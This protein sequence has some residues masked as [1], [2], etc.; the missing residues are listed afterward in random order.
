MQNTD[1]VTYYVA[2]DDT[3]MRVEA[4]I[5]GF[6]GAATIDLSGQ[7]QAIVDLPAES[8]AISIDKVSE[9]YT[10]LRPNF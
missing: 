8:D 3:L 6:K 9:L 10:K 4:D 2:E 7:T 1:A 5:K